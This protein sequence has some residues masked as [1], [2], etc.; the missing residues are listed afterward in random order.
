MRVASSKSLFVVLFFSLVVLAPPGGAVADEGS[1]SY[2]KGVS[3]GRINGASERLAVG[4]RSYEADPLGLIANY[5]VTSYYGLT[6]DSFEVWVCEI[7]GGD[8]IIT[9]EALVRFLDA[10][11]QPFFAWQ[12]GGEYQ[13]EFSAGGT[14]GSPDLTACRDTVTKVSKGGSRGAL[15]FANLDRETGEGGGR[16]GNGLECSGTTVY[17]CYDT[18]PSNLRGALIYNAVYV[19]D[20]WIEIGLEPL[21]NGFASLKDL[22][23]VNVVEN[24]THEMGHTLAFPHSYTGATSSEYDNPMD[25]MGR[26][27]A[28]TYSDESVWFSTDTLSGTI[29]VNRYAA[30]WISPEQVDVYAGGYSSHTLAAIHED[31]TQMLAIPSATAGRFIAMGTRVK[32][33]YDSLIPKEGVEIYLVDQTS[34]ACS[35]PFGGSCWGQNRRTQPYPVVDGDPT[36]HV[37][38]LNESVKIGNGPVVTVVQRIGDSYVVEVD[39][40]STTSPSGFEDVPPGHVAEA[41]IA[42]AAENSITMGVGNNRFG[43]GQTLTRYEMVTFLCRAFDPANCTTGTEG[44]DRFVDVPSG[45]WANY[46]VGWAV[47]RGITRGVTATEFGGSQTLTRE[48]MITFL[49]RAKGEPTG[50]SLGSDLYEDVPDGRNQWANLPIGWAYDQG[51]TGGIAKE[52]FGFGTNLSREE[53]VMF[54]CRTVAAETCQPSQNPLPSSVVPTTRS[55]GSGVG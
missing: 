23:A 21:E 22:L 38:A 39:D 29:A 27:P 31:G 55:T 53:T 1:S 51:I 44:S 30:G 33:G 11:V 19:D 49:Y 34:T 14:V 16:G 28:A 12:S 40:G 45:H 32:R 15:V 17:V 3:T 41:A 13:V 48:Q 52:T 5:Q 50:G 43:V 54:L 47:D 42:W 18:F 10:E 2:W 35:N 4:A 6:P 25:L 36:A 46:S 8:L 9:P 24:T 7:P 26:G 20:P 37:L